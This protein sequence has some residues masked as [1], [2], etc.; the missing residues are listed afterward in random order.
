MTRL[1]PDLI[2]KT[3]GVC[4]G[5]ACI[6][7]TRVPVWCVWR[8]SEFHSPKQLTRHFVRP[9]TLNQ[10]QAALAYASANIDEIDRDVTENEA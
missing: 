7:G 6:A 5:R 10:V 1:T 3:P 2:T 9:L 8:A 4:G